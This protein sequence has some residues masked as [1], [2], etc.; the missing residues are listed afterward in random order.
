MQSRDVSVVHPSGN[1]LRVAALFS[2]GGSR[3][4]AEMT[5]NEDDD[6]AEEFGIS[7]EKP[8]YANFKLP[9]PLV[10]RK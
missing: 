2:V 8:P 3:E 9:S 1:G 5:V 7:C 4:D 10:S 6:Y